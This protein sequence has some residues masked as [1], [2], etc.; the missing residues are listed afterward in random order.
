MDVTAAGNPGQSV[1]AVTDNTSPQWLVENRELIRG[2]QGINAAELFGEGHEV[3]FVRDP[4]TK[5]PVVRVV[6]QQTQEVLWQ[7]PPEYMLRLAAVLGTQEQL[8]HHAPDEDAFN[9][10]A[11]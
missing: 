9:G 6:D 4:E 5:R 3:V 10:Y 11:G 7:A 8:T 2:V 1:P